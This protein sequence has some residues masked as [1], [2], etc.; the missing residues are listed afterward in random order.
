M[1]YGFQCGMLWGVV[2]AAGAQAYRLY[3][4][5][6]RAETGAIIAAQRLV[7]SFRTRNK[8]INCVDIS[9]IDKSSSPMDMV[10]Q[11]LL[12]G[13]VIGCFR[14]AANYAPIAFDDINSEFS[15]TEFEVLAPPVS[16]AAVL[17]QKMGASDLQ[18]VMAAGF[19][20]GI[21]LSG[22]ACGA[23]GAAIWLTSI[24]NLTQGATQ[25]DFNDPRA[26]A[27]VDEFVESSDYEF[28][29]KDIVG[30]KF[31]SVSDHADYVANGGCAKIIEV[32]ANSHQKT[33]EV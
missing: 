22:G 24:D 13:G 23:L 14:M 6:P 4:P 20:G 27:V 33:P 30:R 17:A 31:K 1:Q 32:L 28:E 7:E 19:A 18:T 3:G 5:D 12:K 29:C 10:V 26:S 15:E 11:F 2:L 21:G 16:C 8:S 9:N 25:V